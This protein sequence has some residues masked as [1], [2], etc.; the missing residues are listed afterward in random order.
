MKRKTTEKFLIDGIPL[1]TPDAGVE[2]KSEDLEGVTARDESGFMRRV[3]KRSNVKTWELTY[4]TLMGDEFAYIK[5]LVSGKA[6][7]RF[8]F[9]DENGVKQ[10]TTAYCKQTSVSWWS[11]KRGLYKNLQLRIVEC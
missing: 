9:Y 6:S 8:T 11:A 3:L 10:E 1:L 2:V 7:F 5:A 4:G